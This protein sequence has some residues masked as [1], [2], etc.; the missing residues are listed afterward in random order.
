MVVQFLDFRSSLTLED[1][2]GR[3]RLTRDPLLLGDIGLQVVPVVGTPDQDD[4]RIGLWA[5]LGVRSRREGA[6]TVYIQRGGNEIFESGQIVFTAVNNL[7]GDTGIEVFTVSTGDFPSAADVASGQIRYTMFASYS[8]KRSH[9]ILTG[10][11]T[12]T[13]SAQTGAD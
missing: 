1:N 11:V 2:S 8:G 12:F 7:T 6:I 4:V 9:A 3:I 13:G 5:T 10:P